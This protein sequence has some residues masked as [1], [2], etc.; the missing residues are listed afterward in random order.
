MG[1]IW[2]VSAAAFLILDCLVAGGAAFMA[3]RG[4]AL[5]W[6]PFWRVALY[7]L[8][9]G[10]ATRFLHFA[11]F[12]GTLL[13]LYYYAVDTTILM[14]AAGLGFRLTRARQMAMRYGWLYRRSSPLTWSRR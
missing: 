6:Q 11:L 2:E 5:T 8:I 7:M 1:H 13:S 12:D 9:L 14:L 10:A 3:G 4:M